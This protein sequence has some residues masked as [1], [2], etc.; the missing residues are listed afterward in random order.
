MIKLKL[1][2]EFDDNNSSTHTICYDTKLLGSKRTKIVDD[3]MKPMMEIPEIAFKKTERKIKLLTKD[4]YDFSTSEKEILS[5]KLNQVIKEN[6]RESL[7]QIFSEIKPFALESAKDHYFTT[8][9]CDLVKAGQ[10]KR[11]K[12]DIDSNK[13]N[14]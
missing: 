10:F 11:R 3:D 9:F 6:G 13:K 8:P 2:K 5:E 1:R 4:D 12:Y 14:F 7:Y